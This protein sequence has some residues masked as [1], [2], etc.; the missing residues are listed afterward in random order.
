MGAAG[1]DGRKEHER[2]D[3]SRASQPIWTSPGSTAHSRRMAA[4]TAAWLCAES[5]R[6]IQKLGRTWKRPKG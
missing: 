5:S 4:E 2:K 3:R 1:Q 6:Q